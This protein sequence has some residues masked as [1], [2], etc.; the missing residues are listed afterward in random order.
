MVTAILLIIVLAIALAARA[1]GRL[2]GN[3][4][5]RRTQQGRKAPGDQIRHRPHNA[6]LVDSQVYS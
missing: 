4:S 3:L 2:I 1:A 6:P 5:N